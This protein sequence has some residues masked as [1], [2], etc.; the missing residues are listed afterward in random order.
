MA[1]AGIPNFMY[2][3]GT[4]QL[5]LWKYQATN[6][7]REDFATCC[8]VITYFPVGLSS[9]K[10]V[11]AGT[12]ISYGANDTIIITLEESASQ[13]EERQMPWKV[14][15]KQIDEWFQ[16]TA[17]TSV[18]LIMEN[19]NL[20]ISYEGVWND[21]KTL[22][23][24]IRD[25]SGASPSLLETGLPNL[26]FRV[27]G[28]L[29]YTHSG[30][31]YL[32]GYTTNGS[33][34]I[35]TNTIGCGN[36]GGPARADCRL[37]ITTLPPPSLSTLS[38]YKVSNRI[39]R[40][41]DFHIEGAFLSRNG[42]N[43]DFFKCDRN[44]IALNLVLSH[45][46][47]YYA[48]TSIDLTNEIN[49]LLAFKSAIGKYLAYSSSIL[50][51]KEPREDLLVFSKNTKSSLGYFTISKQSNKN[52]NEIYSGSSP[53]GSFGVDRYQAV[54]FG[55]VN[56]DEIDDYA[57]INMDNDIHNYVWD[58]QTNTFQ[59]TGIWKP[60]CVNCTV[61]IG[62]IK[63]TNRTLQNYENSFL[64]VLAEEDSTLEFYVGYTNPTLVRRIFTAKSLYPDPK[65]TITEFADT[66]NIGIDKRLHILV[67]HSN[68]ALRYFQY[69]P[70]T[71]SVIRIYNT[72]NI[73]AKYNHTFITQP[74]FIDID[75]DGDIDLIS[76]KDPEEKSSS[77]HFAIFENTG[78]ESN[79]FFVYFN[80]HVELKAGKFENSYFSPNQIMATKVR[81]RYRSIM[82]F[83]HLDNHTFNKTGGFMKKL[84]I[85]AFEKILTH[86]MVN[87][88]DNPLV[89]HNAYVS[90]LIQNL[91]LLSRSTEV[92]SLVDVSSIDYTKVH[93][94]DACP[95]IAMDSF[96]VYFNAPVR[97]YII[98]NINNVLK[99]YD[100]SEINKNWKINRNIGTN[101][102]GKWVD[103]ST[104]QIDISDTT[105]QDFD[106]AG[107]LSVYPRSTLPNFDSCVTNS[108]I[109]L[110]KKN[111]SI[112]FRTSSNIIGFKAIGHNCTY[113]RGSQFEITFKGGL[114]FDTTRN[115]SNKANIDEFLQFSPSLGNKYKGDW[116]I[117]TVDDIEYT[118]LLITIIDA[119]NGPTST[120]GNTDEFVT[121]RGI[122]KNQ[123]LSYE[124]ENS[125][126]CTFLD[127]A[128]PPLSGT[129][130]N[131]PQI[132]KVTI[133]PNTNRNSTWGN[134]VVIEI[135]LS[136]ES[137][138]PIG[139]QDLTKEEVLKYF[140][141]SVSLGNQYS[142]T[143]NRF[144]RYKIEILDASGHG[145]PLPGTL[146]FTMQP[147]LKGRLQYGSNGNVTGPGI[148]PSDQAESLPLF[149]RVY[150]TGSFS[151]ANRIVSAVGK[152]GCTPRSYSIGD[153]IVITLA[154]S[155]MRKITGLPEVFGGDPVCQTIF[156]PDNTLNA[157][158]KYKC[159]KMVIYEHLN[160]RHG[161]KAVCIGHVA[162]MKWTTPKTFEIMI[163]D[164]RDDCSG[165]T[166]TLDEYPQAEVLTNKHPPSVIGE[167]SQTHTGIILQELGATDTEFP[168]T[169]VL[170]P[171]FFGNIESTC[172]LTGQFT[173]GFAINF[174]T[175]RHVIIDLKVLYSILNIEVLFQGYGFLV[176]AP[177]IN[178]KTILTT[179]EDI[180]RCCGAGNE[181]KRKPD[182]D[183]I[184]PCCDN[185]EENS[186]AHYEQTTPKMILCMM[187]LDCP[188]ELIPYV[189]KT[190]NRE[191]NTQLNNDCY[192]TSAPCL[193]Q[194]EGTTYFE[195]KI[196][197]RQSS[198][199]ITRASDGEGNPVQD[200]LGGAMIAHLYHPIS[201][202][203]T[204]ILATIGWIEEVYP[205][206]VDAGVETLI[207]IKGVDFDNKWKKGGY[208][209]H[210]YD[211]VGNQLLTNATVFNTTRLTCFTPIWFFKA[212]TV[213][214]EV[215][216]LGIKLQTGFCDEKI[217]KTTNALITRTKLLNLTFYETWTG[218]LVRNS[219][220]N[221][222]L[223]IIQG[224]G[225][226]MSS[227][228]YRC[229]M[230]FTNN[231]LQYVVS[232]PGFAVSSTRIICLLPKW[233]FQNI[234]MTIVLYQHN[235]PVLRR[236][237]SYVQ[238][239]S[240]YGSCK[241]END[242]AVAFVFSFAAS[243]TGTSENNLIPRLKIE[244]DHN[245]YIYIDTSM[246]DMQHL[247]T[248]LKTLMPASDL[249]VADIFVSITYNVTLIPEGIVHTWVAKFSTRSAALI[250]PTLQA[251]RVSLTDAATLEEI[252]NR[253]WKVQ[254]F[255]FN[256]IHWPTACISCAPSIYSGWD[257]TCIRSS[258]PKMKCWGDNKQRQLYPELDPVVLPD[259]KSWIEYDKV[260]FKNF[261]L[262]YT[263]TCGIQDITGLPICYGLRFP[264]LQMKIEAPS[265]L[266]FTS[267][268]PGAYHTC[269]VTVDGKLSCWGEQ[270]HSK[271]IPPNSF[272]HRKES[273]MM[274]ANAMFVDQKVLACTEKDGWKKTPYILSASSVSHSCAIESEDNSIMCWGD[275]SGMQLGA[276]NCNGTLLDETERTCAVT[277]GP[278]IDVA[279]GVQHTCGLFMDG[280]INCW[281]K[282]MQ[283]T[284]SPPNILFKS[285]A[286]GH[287]HVCGIARDEPRVY[288][289]G[290]N[291]KGQSNAPTDLGYVEVSAGSQHTCALKV[292]NEN[293]INVNNVEKVVCWGNYNNRKISVGKPTWDGF[294]TN[295]DPGFVTLM[296]PEK[297][298]SVVTYAS[299]CF[300]KLARGECNLDTKVNY[301][302]YRRCF[303][304]L[305]CGNLFSQTLPHL[306]YNEK[307][308]KAK[309]MQT[310]VLH[311][312]TGGFFSITYG[313]VTTTPI[314]FNA[315]ARNVQTVL[316]NSIGIGMVQ[317][318]C[319]YDLFV[320]GNYESECKLSRWRVEF[321]NYGYRTNILQIQTEML[322]PNKTSVGG[323]VCYRTTSGA[324]A[325][326]GFDKIACDDDSAVLGKD[327]DEFLGSLYYNHFAEINRLNDVLYCITLTEK[328]R[329][330][331]STWGYI[332]TVHSLIKSNI[333]YEG[334]KRWNKKWMGNLTW[335][336]AKNGTNKNMRLNLQSEL[337]TFFSNSQIRVLKK[338][339]KTLC[340]DLRA[341]DAIVF[342]ANKHA[343]EIKVVDVNCSSNGEDIEVNKNILIEYRERL[344]AAQKEGREYVSDIALF[345]TLLLVMV[346]LSSFSWSE[347]ILLETNKHNLNKTTLLSA[348]STKQTS[349]HHDSDSSS[350]S[351]D[352][353]SDESNEG[354]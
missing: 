135:D 34:L 49:S 162:W 274:Y 168:T 232:P 284:P 258:D 287:R 311:G 30:N 323:G 104:F 253:H 346:S 50:L 60:Q 265:D 51:T 164:P 326:L 208:K 181:I 154:Q 224:N 94:I 148:C 296:D 345:I 178:A 225:F 260:S 91:N 187:S 233:P 92:V 183:G 77:K 182:F 339:D 335:G 2:S 46:I 14:N 125:T 249:D 128:T 288:C 282:G 4:S 321:Q 352:D 294:E 259:Q 305:G 300:P 238:K 63:G 101:Y 342:F 130:L 190:T 145:N 169:F 20:G 298:T 209:C 146:Y 186:L 151:G 292:I 280:T 226:N 100:E 290:A 304:V 70:D 3:A 281:G 291:V 235:K 213:T 158:A 153:R 337:Q 256:G 219:S 112:P 43:T 155:S 247:S 189:M 143:W 320:G 172:H 173:S 38:S 338:K 221:G 264:G 255:L 349:G 314:P 152:D 250:I 180:T 332:K 171:I 188:S 244:N 317:V 134:G 59:N 179:K 348:T 26:H 8:D 85:K 64:I 6:M 115:V 315:T 231:S 23:I 297:D 132:E 205:L 57:L 267:I 184:L 107:R 299:L 84:Q 89:A 139:K 62:S 196:L 144:T 87:G 240:L 159:L 243:I 229:R 31:I 36:V 241:Q 195:T 81:M 98:S 211:K 33:T 150:A 237:A 236:D 22:I 127:G 327:H 137:N 276:S 176:S 126:I 285:M 333:Q 318:A 163:E 39:G 185:T 268:S 269:G 192:D 286:S 136:A 13:V 191:G 133:F 216:R 131:L 1:S 110:Q 48:N 166:F 40:F 353:S 263:H 218:T 123:S 118:I 140:V 124:L 12:D 122:L 45:D 336:D 277:Y 230:Q 68:G 53:T 271:S 10:F 35:D 19:I 266:R 313:N 310:I 32:K 203:Y 86:V 307:W 47:K 167:P 29:S 93:D 351:D 199:G 90:V 15:K 82:K 7:W 275:N 242:I 273:G 66:T 278:F 88:N 227:S 72:Q 129:F 103:R 328:D 312:A 79:P 102:S 309:E 202:E 215:S 117:N 74:V 28:N 75:R 197:F 201:G 147:S 302:A 279:L 120:V 105:G 270:L 17:E 16:A 200:K 324:V 121:L 289:W 220:I 303:Q 306:E 65:I 42:D 248:M 5:H 325:R 301:P 175:K 347:K 170:Q 330:G 111:A 95:P 193:L 106:V 283:N 160:I 206:H 341:N 37:N 340:F 114:K 308:K 80:D 207:T 78:T 44:S 41:D 344:L 96:R 343:H 97:D 214:L 223:T 174:P 138:M 177:K 222:G 119:T 73:F 334:G 350:S 116:K 157:R 272:C 246:S 251:S 261:K 54:A 25:S 319:G 165:M 239:H 76:D 67:G 83:S 27:V 316:Q 329:I 24:I 245:Q 228:E 204:H 354:Y 56:G 161:F 254:Q 11:S 210:F 58:D 293:R 109:M 108:P 262:G 18:P 55:D 52:W 99:I 234:D 141:P 198:F 9:I 212:K 331:N 69:S 322:L 149:P 113:G 295:E 21:T 61:A 257:Y 71:K 194:K 142:G 156:D 217:C 252:T